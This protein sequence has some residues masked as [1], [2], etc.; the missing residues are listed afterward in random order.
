MTQ[1]DKEKQLNERA[2]VRVS[3]KMVTADV[4]LA[5]HKKYYK[6]NGMITPLVV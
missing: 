6:S 4:F 3:T 2:V 1:A 5:C